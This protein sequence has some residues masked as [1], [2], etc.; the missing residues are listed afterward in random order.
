MRR[1]IEAG[2]A[3]IEHGDSG[4][5]EIFKLMASRGIALC[6]TLAAGDAILQYNGWKKGI[7]P[8]PGRITAKKAS[9]KAALAAHVPIC[10]G[11]DVGVFAHG[12]NVRELELMVEYGMTTLQ[13]LRSVTSG[14]ARIF[15]M[16]S[17][18]GRIKP[19]LLADLIAVPGDPLQ[20]ISALRQVKLVM[21]EGKLYKQD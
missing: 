12:E 4:T 9:F 17:Q 6:P 16:D 7:D 14:N 8:E 18:I 10:S 1:A 19:G 21:K 15:R 3:T 20:Q 11:G 5:P 13:V 2:V